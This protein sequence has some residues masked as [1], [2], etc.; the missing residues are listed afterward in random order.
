MSRTVAPPPPSSVTSTLWRIVALLTAPGELVEIGT[1]VT[2][3]AG[4]PSVAGAA[5]ATRS[6]RASPCTSTTCTTVPDAAWWP[7]ASRA[8]M[9]TWS[10]LAP[11]A[12]NGPVAA[13]VIVAG[14]PGP[15]MR[16]MVVA[17]RALFAPSGVSATAFGPGLSA[18]P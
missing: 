12:R 3:A 9:R 15:K 4:A 18:T 7:H 6:S 13:M 17:P 5:A 10:A 16:C 1:G 8:S 2:G 11:S 14:R